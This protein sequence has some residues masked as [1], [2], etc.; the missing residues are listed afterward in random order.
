MFQG[1]GTVVPFTRVSIPP[2]A[3]CRSS[4]ARRRALICDDDLRY[5]VSS[6][7]K[8]SLEASRVVQ[9]VEKGK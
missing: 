2:P 5:I 8:A 7:V 9:E 1:Q 4:R 6:R 3:L